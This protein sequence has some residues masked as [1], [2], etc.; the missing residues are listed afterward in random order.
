MIEAGTS[1][2][3]C[4]PS[5]QT[6]ARAEGKDGMRHVPVMVEEVLG[7]LLHERSRVVLD[8]TVGLG[9]HAE[10]LLRARAE[11]RLVGLDR[12]PKALEAAAARLSAFADRVTLARGHYA[13]LDAALATVGRVD[14]VLLDLGVSSPQI[15]DP[16]RGFAH[17][18]SGPLDMRMGPEG[19]TAAELLARSD[20]ESIAR[21]LREY[22]EVTRARRVA[23][24]IRAAADAGAMATTADL[25]AAATEAL[26]RAAAPADLSRVFQAVRIA[27]NDELEGLRRFL[28]HVLDWLHPHGRLV[29]LS[30]HSLED[31]IVKR[32]MRDAA[33]ACVCPP[34]VPVCV[35]GRVPQVR[36]L[37]RRAL[38]PRAEELS[39]NPRARSARLRAAEKLASNPGGAA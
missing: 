19:E 1:Y 24:S 18:A 32:F 21:W 29:I 34:T 5:V 8:G 12:D 31:R 38:R 9:G 15:D 25:R 10:A 7:C 30:Y 6:R 17:G 27:V 16:A 14:G 36:V 4:A 28:S 23:R 11:L 13:D 20:V 2:A 37:T 26:G 33:A 3:P 39:R 22:G 35:C